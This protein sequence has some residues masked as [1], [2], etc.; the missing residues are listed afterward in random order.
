MPS[1]CFENL[2][3]CWRRGK[4]PQQCLR[5]TIKLWEYISWKSI[6]EEACVRPLI[7]VA[8][9]LNAL[10]FGYNKQQQNNVMWKHSIWE[11]QLWMPKATPT[12]KPSYRCEK[13]F[14]TVNAV[15]LSYSWKLTESVWSVSVELG[16]ALGGW[17]GHYRWTRK[18]VC[19]LTLVNQV[20]GPLGG[21]SRVPNGLISDWEVDDGNEQK[22]EGH[23]LTL[24]HVPTS[25]LQYSPTSCQWHGAVLGARLVTCIPQAERQLWLHQ[26]RGETWFSSLFN[27]PIEKLS[28]LC[29]YFTE[30]LYCIHIG[31]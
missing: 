19:F 11:I 13:G 15:C 5:L 22:W 25:V 18:K 31:L 23:R 2:C 9:F 4:L 30:H 28:D 1:E 10:L 12:V 3:Q 29:I 20:N 7:L 24:L 8:S 27:F 26:D 17:L 6:F 21:R 16:N 14:G